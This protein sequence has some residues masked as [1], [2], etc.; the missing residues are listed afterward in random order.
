MMKQNT[1]KTKITSTNEVIDASAVV[2][3]RMASEIQKI[4]D[5]CS[6]DFNRK[7]EV[8]FKITVK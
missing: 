4:V 7:I 5:S 8:E 3:E 2:S 6:K 1:T